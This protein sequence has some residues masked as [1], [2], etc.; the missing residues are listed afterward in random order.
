M[1]TGRDT[2]VRKHWVGSSLKVRLPFFKKNLS[3]G[4]LCV[5]SAHGGQKRAPDP[6]ELEFPSLSSVLTLLRKVMKA[7]RCF[8]IGIWA[9]SYSRGRC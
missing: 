4:A 7:N 5:G 6:L 8:I 9:K 2:G 1:E 3:V